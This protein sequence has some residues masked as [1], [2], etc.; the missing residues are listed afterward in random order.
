MPVKSWNNCVMRRLFQSGDAPADEPAHRLCTV[1]IA[2]GR[3]KVRFKDPK[4]AG[5]WAVLEGNEAGAGHYQLRARNFYG[6]ATLHHSPGENK[7]E[8]GWMAAGLR[9]MWTIELRGGGVFRDPA[10]PFIRGRP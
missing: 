9:A 4:C 2:M 1:Q 8:G 7:L 3:I 5:G 10:R 6:T